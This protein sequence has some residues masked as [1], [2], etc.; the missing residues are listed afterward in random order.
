[1]DLLKSSE[2]EGK[3]KANED[4]RQEIED[5]NLDAVSMLRGLTTFKKS[6]DKS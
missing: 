1:L 4:W 3:M 6:P 5:L 2:V